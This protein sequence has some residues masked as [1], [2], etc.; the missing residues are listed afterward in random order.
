M[1][2]REPCVRP[3]HG[4]QMVTKSTLCRLR[5]S[6]LSIAVGTGVQNI[7]LK[8]KEKSKV[9]GITLIRYQRKNGFHCIIGLNNF[10][11]DNGTMKFI[12]D[13]F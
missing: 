2:S 9:G 6:D 4:S 8:A 1:A 7:T 12:V 5:P 11:T 10:H 3:A 13:F